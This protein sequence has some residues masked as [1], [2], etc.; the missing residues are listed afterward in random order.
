MKIIDS[1]IFWVLIYL[2]SAVLF[3]QSFK[4]ANRNMKNPG[5]LTIL[6]E[7]FTGLFSLWFGN[8]YF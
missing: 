3:S 2:V 5:S 8:I 7:I 1:W 4:K 6:L